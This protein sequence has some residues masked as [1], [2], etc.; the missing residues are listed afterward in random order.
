PHQLDDGLVL[1]LGRLSLDRRHVT[2]RR[3]GERVDADLAA[4]AGDLDTPRDVEDVDALRRQHE[5]A[6]GVEAHALDD[7]SQLVEPDLAAILA[8]GEV[9][10][11]DTLVS[12]VA[13]A[14]GA[15]G[16][17]LAVAAEAEQA[18]AAARIAASPQT[19]ALAGGEVPDPHLIVLAGVR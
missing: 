15:D 5:P 16:Q 19:A 18:D 8:R 12:V 7:V 14:V 6:A 9:V 4:Q 17:G 3:Q 11:V 1:V 13:A 2:G 10:E